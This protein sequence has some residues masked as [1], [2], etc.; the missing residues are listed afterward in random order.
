MRAL[1]KS[2]GKTSKE[3]FKMME[4]GQLGAEYIL[5]F[6]LQMEKLVNVN[7]AYTKSLDK[8]GIVENRMKAAFSVTAAEN[9][10]KGGFT[11]GLKNFFK[12]ITDLVNSNELTLQRLGRI[13]KKVFDVLSVVVKAATQWF[14]TFLRTVE[15]VGQIVGWFVDHPLNGLILALPIVTAYMKTLGKVM[16][17]A[18]KTPFVLLTGIMAIFDEVRAVFDENLIGF[19][20]SD[21]ASL[22]D[23]KIAAAQARLSAGIGNVAEDKKFLSQYSGDRINQAQAA[24][25]GM[26]SYLYSSNFVKAQQN[27]SNNVNTASQSF[28][29]TISAPGKML[30]NTLY[31]VFNGDPTENASAARKEFEKTM[32]LN[33]VG[34]R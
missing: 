19:G 12:T 20:E 23:R 9:L 31:F 15:S 33:V 3:L 34:V 29:E 13:Y 30:G 28:R 1:E 24:S 16:E 21:T 26:G 17:A 8:L 14:A 32:D 27:F 10:D 6:V 11:E 5:P 18:F 4:Q 2:T 25:G 22:E 7:D